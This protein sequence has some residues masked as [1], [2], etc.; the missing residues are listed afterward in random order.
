[1]YDS[2]YTQPGLIGFFIGA[3]DTL[4]FTVEYDYWAYWE[5]P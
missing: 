1:V 3:T 5:N 4:G 2:T